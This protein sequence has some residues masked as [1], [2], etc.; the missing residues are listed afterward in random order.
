MQGDLTDVRAEGSR[1]VV[2]LSMEVVGDRA[3]DGDEASAG[4]DCKEP[5]LREKHIDDVREADAAFAAEHARGF[6]EGQEAVE[7]P[8]IDEFAS[9]VETGVAVTAS[10]TIGKQ[11]ARRG[12]LKD[13]RQLI[14][15]CRFVDV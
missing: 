14:V 4:R 2:I 15:P 12:S 1:T 5:S 7:S 8:A 6:I 3:T 10:E 9:G 13:L 11:G